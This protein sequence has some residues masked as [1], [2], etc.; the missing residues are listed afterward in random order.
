MP[1]LIVYYWVF[2]AS[3]AFILKSRTWLALVGLD[4]E[5]RIGRGLIMATNSFVGVSGLQ[6]L[7]TAMIRVYAGQLATHGYMSPI[8]GDV[9]SRHF[10]TWYECHLRKG[11]AN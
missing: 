2:L 11:V 8:K 1:A 3:A 7:I 6:M 5:G 9:A 4:P 10:A